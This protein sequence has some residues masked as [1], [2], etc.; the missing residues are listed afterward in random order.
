MELSIANAYYIHKDACLKPTPYYSTI[1]KDKMHYKI[2]V[3]GMT[4]YV[5]K[6]LHNFK[7]KFV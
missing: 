7:I 6:I 2:N 3:M 5:L 4:H 1:F